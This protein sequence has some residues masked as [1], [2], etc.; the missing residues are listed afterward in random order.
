MISSISDPMSNKKVYFDNN[1]Q[2]SCV[3]IFILVRLEINHEEANLLGSVV[4]GILHAFSVKW[5]W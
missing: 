2:T 4:E 1:T 5:I 3:Y